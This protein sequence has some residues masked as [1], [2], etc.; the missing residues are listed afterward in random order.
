MDANSVIDLIKL[1]VLPVVS[2]ASGYAF[3]ITEEV[4][5]EIK[6]DKQRNVLQQIINA[7]LIWKVSLNDIEEL[8]L[9]SE[10]TTT[11][12]RGEA[13]SL[14]Y[15]RYHNCYMLSD[16]NNRAFMREVK[17]VITEHRL[18]RTP[19]LLVETIWTRSLSLSD[20]KRRINDLRKKVST[21]RDADDICHFENVLKE[22]E[23]IFQAR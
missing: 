21:Q 4:T 22:I 7:R 2:K 17:R 6:W 8:K 14:A 23:R 19:E 1:D 16:E 5:S 15:A 11:L 18:K 10:L 9:F 3:L 12:G 20:L 13:A